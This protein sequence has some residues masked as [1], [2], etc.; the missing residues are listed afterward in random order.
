MNSNQTA[1]KT[2]GVIII[3]YCTLNLYYFFLASFNFKEWRN[4]PNF[5]LVICY[6]TTISIISLIYLPLVGHSFLG[7]KTA[8]L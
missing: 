7:T 4:Y 2:R 8:D 5:N 6:I 1:P 3:S